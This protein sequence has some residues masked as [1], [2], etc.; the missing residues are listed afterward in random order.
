MGPLESAKLACWQPDP[1]TLSK[2]RRPSISS[3]S[4]VWSS[5]WSVLQS[6]GKCPRCLS[7]RVSTTRCKLQRHWFLCCQ[8]LRGTTSTTLSGVAGAKCAGGGFD[9]RLLPLRSDQHQNLKPRLSGYA[10]LLPAT[11]TELR[12]TLRRLQSSARHR[13]IKNPSQRGGTQTGA[14]RTAREGEQY[15]SEGW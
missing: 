1:L 8:D 2:W 5:W 14:G 11:P 9:I 13:R 15:F 4:F 3:G 12:S 7:R 6:A 10:R